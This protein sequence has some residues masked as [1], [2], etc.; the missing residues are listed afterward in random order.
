MAL[1]PRSVFLAR[2]AWCCQFRPG[3]GEV[4]DDEEFDGGADGAGGV[5]AGVGLAEDEGAFD[6][7]GEAVGEG[8]GVFESA[9]A[10]RA[11]SRQVLRVLR[12]KSEAA[13]WM[14]SWGLGN[15]MAV[16]MNMQP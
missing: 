10:V 8:F 5:V 9:P 1:G 2:G 11:M 14:G 6:E 12:L 4:G 13:W 3:S 7:G 16:F 15:S